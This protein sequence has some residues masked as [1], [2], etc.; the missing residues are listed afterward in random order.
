[1]SSKRTED[2]IIAQAGIEVILGG[3]S[4]KIAP[5]VIRDSRAWRAKLI[6]MIAKLPSLI[7]ITIDTENPEGFEKAL[8]Q[9]M[10]DMPDQIVDLFFEYAK[11]L[12][13]DEIESTATDAEIALAFSEVLK[14]AFPLA[15]SPLETMKHLSP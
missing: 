10:L 2:Q 11:D 3:A 12:N 6:P 1:M 13:R 15:Q 8:S 5:L 4:F 14:V 7:G 9:M